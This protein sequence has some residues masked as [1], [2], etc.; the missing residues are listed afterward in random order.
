MQE[1]F[2]PSAILIQNIPKK[3]RAHPERRSFCSF[4]LFAPAHFGPFRSFF[5]CFVRVWFGAIAKWNEVTRGPSISGSFEQHVTPSSCRWR[6][7]AIR[8]SAQQ[9]RL[10]DI[11]F[12]MQEGL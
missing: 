4:F 1:S 8:T 2:L 12:S 3:R 7:Q 5:S 11:R 10:C 9:K 6:Q